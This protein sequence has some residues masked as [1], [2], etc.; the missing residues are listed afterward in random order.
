[1]S[2]MQ[3]KIRLIK[4]NFPEIESNLDSEKIHDSEA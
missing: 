3:E 1:M 4:M 2:Q